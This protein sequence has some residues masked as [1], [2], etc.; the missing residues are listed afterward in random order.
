MLGQLQDKKPKNCRYIQAN[1]DEAETFNQ[2]P[3]TQLVLA[4]ASLHWSHDLPLALQR[5][6]SKIK[7]KGVFLA[8]FFLPDTFFELQ[9]LLQSSSLFEAVP[10]SRFQDIAS[11]K[12]SVGRDFNIQFSQKVTLKQIYPS[13]KHLLKHI[14]RTGVHE[15]KNT[16]LWTPRKF[17][18]LQNNYVKQYG[19]IIATASFWVVYATT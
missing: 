19:S 11:I 18:D 17:H 14:K 4:N 7:E 12:R 6:K 13:L 5:I 1:F 2:L 10:A 8:T 9:K 16:P 15:K 3:A